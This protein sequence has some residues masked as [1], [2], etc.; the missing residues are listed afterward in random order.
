VSHALGKAALKLHKTVI[1]H[2]QETFS[3]NLNNQE[4]YLRTR[5]EISVTVKTG[6][7]LSCYLELVQ[8]LGE[9]LL[10]HDGFKRTCRQLGY[11][12][13]YKYVSIPQWLL[14]LGA[15]DLYAQKS[16]HLYNLAKPGHPI[17]GH[18]KLFRRAHLQWRMLLNLIGYSNIS[19]QKAITR[20]WADEIDLN[21]ERR[22]AWKQDFCAGKISR[23]VWEEQWTLQ[24]SKQAQLNLVQ[25]LHQ[26]V[27]WTYFSHNKL[28]AIKGVQHE[29][30]FSG[31]S[32][33]DVLMQA[34][35]AWDGRVAIST[36]YEIA[37]AGDKRPNIQFVKI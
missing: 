37:D 3:D 31:K 7:P 17:E 4:E 19:I 25:Q 14:L 35:F 5:V 27:H 34:F 28:Y 20:D 2:L 13:T 24:F 22:K 8:V 12:L 36:V 29:I 18:P 23:H 16:S 1:P 10:T 33:T 15:V 30:K 21:E 11:K 6:L 26:Q 32:A 9:H